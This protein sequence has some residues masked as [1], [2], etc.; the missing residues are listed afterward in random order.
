MSVDAVEDHVMHREWCAV[1]DVTATA[2]EETRRAGGRVVAVGTTVVRALE[3]H[4]D[5]HGG[6]RPGAGETR[7]FLRPG[8]AVTV[9]DLLVTNFHLPG[10]TLL[11]LLEAFMG[12]GWRPMYDAALERGYRFLSFGDAMLAARSVS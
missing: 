10:S 12:R 1:S 5:G 4:S 7:L 6:V 8:V 11:V 9:A 3:A 2:I